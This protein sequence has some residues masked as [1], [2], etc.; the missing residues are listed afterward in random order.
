MNITPSL[1]TK[2]LE[3]MAKG[4]SLTQVAARVG[5][6]KA[7]F[8]RLLTSDKE[9]EKLQNDLKDA[10]E[11]GHTLHE[12]HFEDFYVEA[13]KGETFKIIDGKVIRTDVKEG[14]IKAYMQN[15]FKWADKTENKESK[16]S[17]A[18]LSDAEL[19]EQIEKARSK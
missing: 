16:D 2:V 10:I 18:E 8:N 9:D 11:Y 5:M 14:L 7:K 4:S 13:M 6:S 17:I 19:A 12:A 15:K 1:I 3:L